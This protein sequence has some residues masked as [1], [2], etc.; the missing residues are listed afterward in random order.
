MSNQLS[1]KGS[2]M[3]RHAKNG[4]D[5]GDTTIPFECARMAFSSMSPFYVWRKESL[6]VAG[7][8][9]LKIVD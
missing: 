2:R 6:G 3:A 4:G 8:S 1:K 7:V 5:A 9:Y